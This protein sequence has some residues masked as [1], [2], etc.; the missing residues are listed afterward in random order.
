SIGKRPLIYKGLCNLLK[1]I[2][3]EAV[4]AYGA[5]GVRIIDGM[6]GRA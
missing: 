2:V 6:E 4:P 5:C 3:A 1:S